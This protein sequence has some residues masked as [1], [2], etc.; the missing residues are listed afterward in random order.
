[1]LDIE[2]A[3]ADERDIEAISALHV[4]SWRATYRGMLPEAFLAGPVIA[5]RLGLWRSRLTPPLPEHQLV[6]KAV[7]GSLVVGFACVLLTSELDHGCLLDN[8]HVKPELTGSGIGRQLFE[9]ALA[10]ARASSRR[11]GGTDTPGMHLWVLE[12]NARARRFYERAG[13]VSAEQRV[14]EVAT[15]I[16]AAEVRYV[17]A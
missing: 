3:D 12:S 7:R 13:G 9:E 16:M 17:W 1:L 15:G 6:R 5:D 2:T 8:L 14:C 11:F 4:E 10:W